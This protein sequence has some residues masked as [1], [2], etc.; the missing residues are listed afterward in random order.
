MSFQNNIIL[1][2]TQNKRRPSTP[3]CSLPIYNFLHHDLVRS[4]SDA[5]HLP[6]P[7]LRFAGLQPLRHTLG[8]CVLF[9]QPKKEFLRLLLDVCKVAVQ[10]PAVSRL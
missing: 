9:Y 2:C 8:I 5:V 3:A 10:Y 6:Y 7:R 1:F 4:V